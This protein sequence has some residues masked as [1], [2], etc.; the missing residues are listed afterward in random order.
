MKKDSEYLEKKSPAVIKVGVPTESDLFWAQH[1]QSDKAK[2]IKV[3]REPVSLPPVSHNKRLYNV[4]KKGASYVADTVVESGRLVYRG[5]KV[6][7]NIPLAL[8]R[9]NPAQNKGFETPQQIV[10][11]VPSPPPS[12]FLTKDLL[13][14]TTIVSLLLMIAVARQPIQVLREITRQFSALCVLFKEIAPPAY[15]GKFRQLVDADRFVDNRAT[16]AVSSPVGVGKEKGRKRADILIH[17]AFIFAPSQELTRGS[18]YIANKH[19]ANKH[20]ANTPICPRMYGKII[21]SID[22]KTCE[23]AFDLSVPPCFTF[24]PSSSLA[25]WCYMSVEAAKRLECDFSGLDE[26]MERGEL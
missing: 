24:K 10:T 4:C 6:E 14:P 3:E 13:T 19:I 26:L 17:K 15:L 5:G 11:P 2:Q 25:H 7:I 23:L 22:Y 8:K 21:S 18:M 9:Y 20:I 12:Y 1:Y 16:F